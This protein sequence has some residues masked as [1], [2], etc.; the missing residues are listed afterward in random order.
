MRAP[1]RGD[2]G[3]E[4]VAR[5]A[6]AHFGDP[7]RVHH[8]RGVLG[9]LLD[10]EDAGVRLVRNQLD[11][12]EDLL[13]QLG[14]QTQRRLVAA[15]SLGLSAALALS[16]GAAPAQAGG[17]TDARA[18]KADQLTGFGYR[19]D[20]YGVNLVSMMVLAR[21]FTPETFGMVASITSTHGRQR[22]KSMPRRMAGPSL[23]PALRWYPTWRATGD[24]A[25]YDRI[26]AAGYAPA[27]RASRI[28]P[29]IALRQ[30]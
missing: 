17:S 15:V 23:P 5:R 7:G 29:M 12:P 30:D 13:R 28:S 21:L 24:R 20:V 8:D 16:T 4:A 6:E 27:R 26:I 25:A 11:Q 22:S 9:H 2:F 19:G 18:A 1:W 3:Q 14:T 10:Q